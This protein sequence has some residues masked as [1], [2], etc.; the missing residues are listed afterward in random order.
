MDG[1]KMSTNL[2]DRM[3]SEEINLEKRARVIMDAMDSYHPL[4]GRKA[5]NVRELALKAGFYYGPQNSTFSSS[6][7]EIYLKSHEH[8]GVENEFVA[9]YVTKG[10]GGRVALAVSGDYSKETIGDLEGIAGALNENWLS[11]ELMKTPL[12]QL[13]FA[14]GGGAISACATY[15]STMVFGYNRDTLFWGATGTSF[16]VM[17]SFFFSATMGHNLNKKHGSGLSEN[18]LSYHFGGDVIKG[19]KADA[20]RIQSRS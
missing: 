6:G 5:D 1:K 2:V 20:A 3:K 9:L 17:A 10:K 7:L 12:T 11:R 13:Q 14:Y 16:S 4:I 8:D 18:A 19:L 15:V